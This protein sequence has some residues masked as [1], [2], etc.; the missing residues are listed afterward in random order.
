M[1]YKYVLVASAMAVLSTSAN[2]QIGIDPTVLRDYI[3]TSL[4]FPN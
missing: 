4:G 2:A 3:G 1:F